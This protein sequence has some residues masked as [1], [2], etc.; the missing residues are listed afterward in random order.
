MELP[1]FQF[2]KKFIF[3]MLNPVENYIKYYYQFRE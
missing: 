2:D 1:E 3:I